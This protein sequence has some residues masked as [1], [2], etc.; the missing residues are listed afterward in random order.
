MEKINFMVDLFTF[1]DNEQAFW[2]LKLI[3]TTQNYY[4]FHFTYNSYPEL[5]SFIFFLQDYVAVYVYS[6]LVLSAEVQQ[7]FA[8][9]SIPTFFNW[10]NYYYTYG[11]FLLIFFRADFYTCPTHNFSWHFCMPKQV[12]KSYYLAREMKHIHKEC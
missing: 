4:F 8:H 12:I 9:D 7:T 3:N 11:I 6:I 1:L 10:K 2:H 5:Y